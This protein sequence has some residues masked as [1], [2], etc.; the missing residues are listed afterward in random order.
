MKKLI[1]AL[2]LAF[3]GVSFAQIFTATTENIYPGCGSE[4][5][6]GGKCED[7]VVSVKYNIAK[8]RLITSGYYTDTFI[9]GVR[10]FDADS[11]RID[12]VIPDLTVNKYYAGDD[13]IVPDSLRKD[14][15][16]IDIVI[17]GDDDVVASVYKCYRES[18]VMFDVMM[19]SP[20]STKND[21]SFCAPPDTMLNGMIKHVFSIFNYDHYFFSPKHYK[22]KNKKVR[23][24]TLY[25][26]FVDTSYVKIECDAGFY[27]D[28][29]GLDFFAFADDPCNAKLPAGA[30]VNDNGIGYHMNDE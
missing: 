20:K 15:K 28:T 7:H 21:Y 2:L 23:N 6:I 14:V 18:D 4:K 17:Y 9:F 25:V 10:L 1:F 13:F 27:A 11:F 24:K 5:I 29:A 12:F 16:Y 30:I 26:E 8:G 19:N 22:L 3:S